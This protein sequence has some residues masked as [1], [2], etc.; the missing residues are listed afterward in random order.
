VGRISVAEA[1]QRLGVGVPRVHQRI[2]DGSL[3]AVRVGSQWVVDEAS[4]LLVAESKVAGRPL[5]RRS[6]WALLAV[7]MADQRALGTLASVER[8]RARNRLRH[9]LSQ[10][11]PD[12][13]PSEAQVGSAASLLRSL[14]RNRAERRLYRASPRDLAGLRDDDRVVLSGLSHPRSGIASGNFV[15][16]YIAAHD[17]E[18]VVH[19]Y[20]L[21]PAIVDRDANVVLHATSADIPRTADMA[22]LLLAG[23]LAEHRRPREEARAAE[24]LR[25]I[26]QEC[27][28]LVADSRQHRKTRP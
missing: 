18:A 8:S 11:P 4:L 27:P 9:L 21:S 26:V 25:E 7:S 17:I 13:A 6:A 3:P 19:D 14:L 15:E 2:A 28:G 23:D 5:S 20:L 16:G 1:A 22:P 12:R 10:L 24:L